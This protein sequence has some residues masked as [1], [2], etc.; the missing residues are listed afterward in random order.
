MKARIRAILTDLRRGRNVD[1]YLAA[2]AALCVGVLGLLGVADLRWIAPILLLCI[3]P[4]VNLVLVVH[5]KLAEGSVQG[6]VPLREFPIDR[7]RED[8]ARNTDVLLVGVT[9]IRTVRNHESDLVR[10]LLAGKRVRILLVDPDDPTAMALT[11]R[12][13]PYGEEDAE[14][15]ASEVRITLSALAR[16]VAAVPDGHLEVRTIDFPIGLGG[17]A[18]SPQRPDA[19][20]YVETYP[21]KTP[22]T[23]PHF[24]VE[25]AHLHWFEH[26]CLELENLWKA[27]RAVTQLPMVVT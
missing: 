20:M 26:F 7:L 9:L 12:R 16:V 27:G 22:E 4:V 24:V 13:R 15:N 11:D 25:P 1:A 18:F 5:D 10:R 2:C 21:F 17:F 23:Q 3:V 8:W 6:P 14:G 19:R